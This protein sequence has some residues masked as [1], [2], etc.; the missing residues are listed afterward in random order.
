MTSWW[1]SPIYRAGQQGTSINRLEPALFG[2]TGI[3]PVGCAAF[4]LVLGVTAGVLIRRTV[5]AMAVTL[6][7]FTAVQLT[8]ALWI[9]PH[10]IT[11]LQAVSPLNLANLN[12]L[13]ID[14]NSSMTVIG[15]VTKPAAWVLA[16]Q[17]IDTAGHVFTGPATPACLSQTASQQACTASLARLHL[18][19]LLT[20]QPASRYWAFQWSETAIFLVLAVALAGF[21]FWRIQRRRLF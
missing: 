4:A 20:Y 18:R 15:A 13:M 14:N 5:P 3:V 6:A 21:C 10:L 9:R 12:G 11:A 16:N 7:A 19:Q 2:G 1:A 17:T 8:M